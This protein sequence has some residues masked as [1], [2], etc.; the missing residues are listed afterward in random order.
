MSKID[1]PILP[2]VKG[3][4]WRSEWTSTVATYYENRGVVTSAPF[5][6]LVDALDQTIKA[7]NTSY[8]PEQLREEQERL[9][10]YIGQ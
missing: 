9:A 1:P 10:W 5:N 8:T 7:L 2:T 4:R 3:G 6:Q